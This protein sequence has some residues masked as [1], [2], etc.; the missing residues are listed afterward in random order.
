MQLIGINGFKESGKDTAYACIKRLIEGSD[1]RPLRVERRAFA[2]NLKIMA[3]LSLGYEGTDEFLIGAMNKMKEGGSLGSCLD[4]SFDADD[5]VNISGRKYLQNFGQ[6][7]RTV[8][9]DSFWVDQVVPL[10]GFAFA[11]VWET[12]GRKGPF[13]GLPFLGCVT[14]V[15]YPNE[16]QRVK[17]VG[18]QVWEIVRPGL[19]SDGHSSETPL[20]RALVDVVITNDG[21]VADLSEQL[22]YQ[23]R[24]TKLHQVAA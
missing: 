13:V 14:D 19:V 16:A 18:G 24:R 7:A 22:L 5:W 17:D 1:N 6:H 20:D 2:D 10:D 9:G 21:S 8:F 3:A 15:R 4:A 12:R 11:N 23:L